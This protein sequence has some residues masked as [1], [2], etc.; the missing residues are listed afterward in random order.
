MVAKGILESV[1]S[2]E[3]QNPNSPFDKLSEAWSDGEPFSPN[4]G[5]LQHTSVEQ[6]ERHIRRLTLHFKEVLK[7]GPIMN[8]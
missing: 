5:C 3:Q 7:L 6:L 8:Y 2:K 4:L 1:K